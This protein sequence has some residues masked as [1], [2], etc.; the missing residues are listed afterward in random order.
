MPCVITQDNIHTLI[1]SYYAGEHTY[2]HTYISHRLGDVLPDDGDDDH[3]TWRD[4]PARPLLAL[5]L[6]DVGRCTAVACG[7]AHTLVAMADG[8]VVAWGRNSRCRNVFIVRLNSDNYGG[9]RALALTQLDCSILCD[10]A[11]AFQLSRVGLCSK[12]GE[13]TYTR[14]YMSYKQENQERSV[15]CVRDA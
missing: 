11:A 10:L 3:D 15:S 5:V 13:R 1:H 9:M 4:F 7:H 6:G 2:V 8:I 14:A 12:A